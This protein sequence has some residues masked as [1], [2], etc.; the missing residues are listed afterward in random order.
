[1]AL[2]K[3]F[4]RHG[5]KVLVRSPDEL[6][7]SG[8]YHAVPMILGDQEDE[9]TIF[10]LFQRRIKSNEDLVSYLQENLFSNAT[11][12]QMTELVQV[13]AEYEDSGSP[14]RT[15]PHN[16]LYPMF[17][18]IAAMFGDF[19][20]TLSRRRFLELASATKPDAPT[21]SYLSSYA[22]AIPFL[23]TFHGSDLLQTFYGVPPSPAT[24]STRRYYFNFL[25][26]LNPNRGNEVDLN[27]P[28]WKDGK[29]LMWFKSQLKNEYLLDAFRIKQ[30]EVLKKVGRA[31]RQ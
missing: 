28:R 25:Y 29:I 22:H 14:H 18:Q 27:W 12:E 11:K 5:G 2:R 26:N 16:T 31:M 19:Q 20:F 3:E 17:K 21:W 24:S 30:Y 4:Q 7:E 15:G 1:M 10:A 13:Y 6:V 8:T 23:G 9:G